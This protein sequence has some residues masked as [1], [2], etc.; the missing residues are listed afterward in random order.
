M[1]STHVSITLKE[2]ALQNLK[3]KLDILNHFAKCGVPFSRSIKGEVRFDPKTGKKVLDFCPLSLS[4]FAKWTTNPRINPE[5]Q[6]CEWTKKQYDSFISHSPDTL[7]KYPKL[8]AQVLAALKLAKIKRQGQAQSENYGDK[9]Q[10]IVNEK[11]HW[12]AMAESEGAKLLEYLDRALVAEK[13]EK[14]IDR[15]FKSAKER[16]KQVE[17][18][19]DRTI[20]ELRKLLSQVSRFKA[21][22]KK[23]EN[24][25]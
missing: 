25:E 15:A 3:I 9:I 11:D 13:N 22:D 17:E 19:K 24:N 14:A 2:K 10:A 8:K 5:F 4:Q 1:P 6:N 12:K 23:E 20:A 16:L 7:N 18:S 21:V